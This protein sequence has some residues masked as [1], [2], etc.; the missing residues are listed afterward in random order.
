MALFSGSQ[1]RSLRFKANPPRHTAVLPSSGTQLQKSKSYHGGLHLVSDSPPV[2]QPLVN[3]HHR[4]DQGVRPLWEVLLG[5]PPEPLTYV[6]SMTPSAVS[7]LTPPAWNTLSLPHSPY[8]YVQP[9]QC[10]LNSRSAKHFP[11]HTDLCNSV[12]HDLIPKTTN[13]SSPQRGRS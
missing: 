1:Q 8:P 11:P 13:Y 7:I 3:A 12:L 4:S 2:N 5:Q 9:L 6:T 10:N